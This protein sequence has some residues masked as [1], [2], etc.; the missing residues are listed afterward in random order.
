MCYVPRDSKGFTLLEVLIAVAVFLIFAIGIYSGIQFIFKSVYQSRLRI[1]ETG[2]LNEQVEIIR[3]LPFHSVGILGGSPPGTLERTVTTTRNG[4]DFTITRTIRNIDDPFDGTIGGDPNDLSPADYKLVDIDII[5]DT[6]GQRSPLTI[7]S[8]VAPKYLEGD[9]NNGALFVRVFDANA[10]PVQDANVHIVA[11]STDPTFDF[12]DTT[13]NDG[14]LRVV[15]LP[16]AQ[17]A[18]HITV[19]KGSDFTTDQTISPSVEVENPTRPPVSVVAQDVTEVS[20][21]IDHAATLNIQT[22]DTLCQAVASVPVNILGTK[23]KGTNP[24]VFKVDEDVTTS[25]SG[26]Y[27]RTGTEWDFYGLRISNYDLLGAIPGL[28]VNVLPGV[29]QP[30]QVVVGPDTP[31]SLVVHVQDGVT[32]QP[33]SN[34]TVQLTEN[35][36]DETKTTGVGHVRQTDWSGGSGQD[37]YI[38]QSQYSTD[39]GNIDA[40]TSPGN[41]TLRQVGQQYVSSG[42]VVSSIIDLGTIPNY[43]SIQW[44]PL[45]QPAE[46]GSDSLKFQIASSD[47]TATSTWDYLGPDGTANTYYSATTNTIHDIH[48]GDQFMRYKAIFNTASTTYTPT[49]SDVSVTYTN[50]CTPPGQV[51]FGSLD[52]ETYT[53]DVTATGYQASNQQVPVDGDIILTVDLI[54]E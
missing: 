15:D 34:A 50:S 26:I 47:S 12:T 8:Q 18:Y 40:T 23:L 52:D 10:Q 43:V 32:Q 14:Y 11:T 24:D 5:C 37:L 9:P 31:D 33:L 35:G 45:A 49:L 36:Y 53:V 7:T 42:N 27:E 25:G 38:N 30:I 51:Y 1:I 29:Q 28:P 39:D 54:S 13:D 20:F 16:A 44:E 3:N 46:T 2:V 6:C 4:I 17:N 22:V 41:V 21:S 19:S 48:D